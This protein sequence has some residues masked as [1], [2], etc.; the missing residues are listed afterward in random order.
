MTPTA[1]QL[2]E[3][4]EQAQSTPLDQIDVSN[5]EL[6]KND[7][8]APWFDRLRN[9]APV[10]HLA[11]S[12]NGPF[13]SVT[14]HRHIKDV[15]TN[16]EVFSSEAGGISIVELAEINTEELQGESFIQLD[17]PRHSQQRQTVSHP[18]ASG[19]HS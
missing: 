5:P 12:V 18:R 1:D 4:Y 3:A 19:R 9:E 8:W 6:Y 7:T 13:W 15:D 14:N 11:D 16:H 17:E 10:H 2:S